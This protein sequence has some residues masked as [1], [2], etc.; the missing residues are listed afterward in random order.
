MKIL[1]ISYETNHE[2][3]VVLMEDGKILFAASEERYSRIKMDESSP[4]LAL[5]DCFKQTGFSPSDID[6]VAFSGFPPPK[7]WYFYAKNFLRQKFFGGD[8]F[9]VGYH[10]KGKNK[11]II[12]LAALFVNLVL[13]TGVPQF[14]YMYLFRRIRI[15]RLLKGF[16]GRI[17]YVSHHNCHAASACFLSG[18]DKALSIVVEGYDWDASMV[19]EEFSNGELKPIAKTLWPHSPGSFY[20]LVTTIIGFNPHRHA[21]KITGLAAFGDPSVLYNKVAKL[22]WVEGLSLVTS[23]LVYKLSQEYILKGKLPSYFVNHRKEDI[24]A[25]FQKRLEDVMTG[26][27]RKA[28]IATGKTTI[29]LAGGVAGNVLM[30]QKIHEIDEVKNIFVQPA[31]SDMGQCLGA[32]LYAYNKVLLGQGSYLKSQPLKDVYLGPEY[33]QEEIKSALDSSGLKYSFWGD[34]ESKIAE[35]L[36]MGKVVARFNGRMEF[37]P[38]ALGNRSILANAKDSTINIWL[39]KKL[40]RTEFMPFA[41]SVLYEYKDRYFYGVAGAEHTAEFMTITF[42]CTEEMKKKC[43]AV[44]HIDGTA[45]PN[46]VK[47]KTNPSYYKIIKAYQELTGIGVVLNT[48]FNMHEEPIVCTPN[49]AVRS[50]KNGSLDFLAIGNYLISRY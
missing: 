9:V 49:D 1:G 40:V 29:V 22:M 35:L 20:S 17:I 24:A 16:R 10:A 37:G 21:G 50:F 19:I 30:N 34:I 15:G 14:F 47:S 4:V 28:V 13:C 32:A 39:N 2:S 44:V 18:F 25:S 3:G 31:M 42:S 43:P 8:F 12:G 41:P 46:F 11:T 7:N 48:S 23:P 5:K 33:S 36:A 38:R 6:I 27:V 45:R 26:I